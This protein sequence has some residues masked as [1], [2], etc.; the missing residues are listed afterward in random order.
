ME[1]EPL[2]PPKPPEVPTDLDLY[3]RPFGPCVF[4]V[5]LRS[6]INNALEYM[7]AEL[8]RIDGRINYLNTKID[9]AR[10]LALWKREDIE[11]IREVQQERDSILQSGDVVVCYPTDVDAKSYAAFHA[12][13]TAFIGEHRCRIVPPE[14]R[15]HLK[16]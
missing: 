16:G 15:L 10:E 3:D 8:A 5:G 11:R 13:I 7:A 9:E 1:R 6:F 14:T 12:A 2:L 4:G